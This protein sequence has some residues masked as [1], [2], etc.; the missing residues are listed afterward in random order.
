MARAKDIL[1]DL[2]ERAIDRIIE[3]GWEDRTPFDAIEAQFGV[4]ESQVIK[5]MRNQ[6]KESS[7]RMWRARVQGRSTKHV[8][9]RDPEM[10]RF[11]CSRQRHISN[12]KV[13]KR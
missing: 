5:I 3:M 13:S 1:R 6:M 9:Q 11:R 12:N 2:D 10:D 8:A 7:F 4:T